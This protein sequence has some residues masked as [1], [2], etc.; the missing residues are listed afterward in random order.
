M[1]CLQP[2]RSGWG[3]GVGRDET[4]G[5]YVYYNAQDEL[6]RDTSEGRGGSHGRQHEYLIQTRDADHPITRGLPM[7]W[8]H[9]RDELYDRQRA[10]PKRCMSWQRP[11]S[12][13]E[14]GGDRG[15]TNR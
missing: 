5:P 13:K 8:L 15:G 11:T 2:E 7:Q 9:A 4:F 12:D 3:A 14:T 10:R 6:V 1:A